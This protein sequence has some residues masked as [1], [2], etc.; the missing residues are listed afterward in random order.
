[1]EEFYNINYGKIIGYIE[2]LKESIR[3]YEN[4]KY[5][6]IQKY[7]EQSPSYLS[8]KPR[9]ERIATQITQL[10]AKDIIIKT[11]EE[12]EICEVIMKAGTRLQYRIESK[13]RYDPLRIRISVIEGVKGGML[14]ISQTILRPT[15]INCDKI[16]ELNSHEIVLIYHSGRECDMLFIHENIYITIEAQN[17][18]ELT[19]QCVFG[20]SNFPL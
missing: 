19:F 11:I 5:N 17:D 15:S 6:K 3:K 9:F 16:V 13:K 20:K 12:F 10:M 1:M 4:E 7:I 8:L 2:K 14:F 18:I